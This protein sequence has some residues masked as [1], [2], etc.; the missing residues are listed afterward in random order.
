[1]GKDPNREVQDRLALIFA[2][3]LERRSA[4]K[5]LQYCNAHGLLLPRRDR[6]GEVTWRRPTR[7][8]I[9]AIRKHPA[10]A[11]TFVYG[12]SRTSHAGLAGARKQVQRLPMDQWRVRISDVYAAYIDWETF[13]R[14]QAMLADNYAAYERT[15]S[16]GVPRAGQALLHGIIACG[17]CGHKMGVLY[18]H[19]VRYRCT[20]LRTRYQSPVC[21]SV[22]GAPSDAAVA[23]AFFEA[24]AP[25]E[26]D[27]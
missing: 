13:E 4:N 15:G 17:E 2:T 6:F 5:V 26:L 18:K 22:P 20:A 10:Y 11:G 3:F 9:L 8:A 25:V 24:F 16:R 21:Q 27:A 1:M 14:I 23:A 12:R 19:G 7:S